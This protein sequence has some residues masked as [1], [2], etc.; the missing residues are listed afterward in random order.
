MGLPDLVAGSLA[1]YEARGVALAQDGLAEVKGRLARNLRGA[2]LFDA[3]THARRLE[4]AYR[5]M[6]ERGKR[7]L[8][9]QSF[10]VAE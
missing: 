10:A 9:P 1:D 6:W 3:R 4:Q 7:G 5:G 2:P 8:A